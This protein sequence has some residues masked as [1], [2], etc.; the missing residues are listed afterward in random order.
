M[1]DL[2][3]LDNEE[4]EILTRLVASGKQTI[5]DLE[6]TECKRY[7]LSLP[8]ASLHRRLRWGLS[9]KD[10]L[11]VRGYVHDEGTII[12]KGR[13]KHYYSLTFKGY[14]ASSVHGE[15]TALEKLVEER[16]R[17]GFTSKEEASGRFKLWLWYKAKMKALGLPPFWV[18]DLESDFMQSGWEAVSE[19][20][21]DLAAHTSGGAV[22]P[23]T[24]DLAKTFQQYDLNEN[25]AEAV[26]KS[27]L[28]S[29]FSQQ[30]N[31]LE[32]VETNT[33][34]L[35]GSKLKTTLT[36]YVQ[37]GCIRL[38]L[39]FQITPQQLP[40]LFKNMSQLSLEHLQSM[41][42]LVSI[43]SIGYSLECPVTRSNCIHGENLEKRTTCK[44]LIAL[45][46]SEC[47]D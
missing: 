40:S 39:R 6:D 45:V 11:V 24:I 43:Y 18:S 46:D 3:D 4:I 17:F 35:Y 28:P 22:F 23:V 13:R 5:Y 16:K 33:N 9:G 38:G 29:F 42:V 30:R 7:K 47:Q 26:A 21:K 20:V 15:D 34:M 31:L 32:F 19:I 14:L 41:G 12:E 25:E 27:L 2:F 1:K 10:S 37:L 44:H 8:R 36:D